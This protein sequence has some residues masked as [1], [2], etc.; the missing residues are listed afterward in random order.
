MSTEITKPVS[1]AQKKCSVCKISK[2]IT[3]F[4]RGCICKECAKLAQRQRNKK[5]KELQQKIKADPELKNKPKTCNECHKVKRL[6]DF[7]VNRGEC[8][9]CERSFGRKYNKEHP[10]I[11]QKWQDENREH[12]D[13]LRA[14]RYQRKKP[15]IRAKYNERYATDECF[16]LQHQMKRQ[17][18]HQIEKVQ[19]ADS[20]V[21]TKFELT[22]CWLESNFTDEMLWSNHG[23]VWDV[24]HVIPISKWDLKDKMQAIACFSWMNLSPVLCHVNRNQK[25]DKIVPSQV[26]RH[27]R[28]LR[29]YF[30]DKKLNDFKLLAFLLL[31]RDVIDKHF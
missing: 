14:Q 17:L 9:D 6:I 29:Q 3:A 1:T 8:I 15:E 11:R 30:I 2:P 13:E 27:L 21:G 10:D 26:E 22:A 31:C 25:R 18:L 7:R 12:F 19:L 4:Y 16:K 28:L 23:T 20:Y 5:G 24:D